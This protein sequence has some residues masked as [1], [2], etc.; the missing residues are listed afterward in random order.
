MRKICILGKCSS[1]RHEAPLNDKSWE[2]WTL[3][4]DPTPNTHRVFELHQNW[5]EF[6]GKDSE[7][8]GIH[9]RTILGY[10]V[11]V[12]M[13]E[14][15]AD[16]PMCRRYPMEDVT[17]LVGKTSA[18]HP[19]LESSI[20]YMMA[21]AIIECVPGDRIGLWGIDMAADT[22]YHYQ[23]PNMEYLIGLARGKG[24]KV[25]IPPESALMSHAHGVPYGFF[26]P[27]QAGMVKPMEQ[28]RAE[29]AAL[30]ASDAKAFGVAAE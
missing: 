13:L 25:F 29:E 10:R 4:W 11:P 1:T 18:G 27:E 6:H 20:A 14:Q 15:E 2:I 30:R 8:A 9:Y 28:V 5:R 3:A 22:E 12:F 26:T 23:R 17:A 24:L 19:Y 7:D 21:L 16:V